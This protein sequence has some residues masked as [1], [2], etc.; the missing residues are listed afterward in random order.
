M[1]KRSVILTEFAV[2]VY[3]NGKVDWGGADEFILWLIRHKSKDGFLPY[4]RRFQK[5]GLRP[6]RF[7][8]G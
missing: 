3:S 2:V 7:R 8:K 4:V 5:F 1:R 6:K